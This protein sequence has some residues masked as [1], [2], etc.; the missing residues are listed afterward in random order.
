MLKLLA[1]STVLL[2]G[3]SSCCISR[4]SREGA[5]SEKPSMIFDTTE[6]VVN[7]GDPLNLECGLD[8]E[9]RHCIWMHEPD[10]Y[11][12]LDVYSNMYPGL[13]E[14]E[15]KENNQCGIIVDSVNIKHHG[16]WTC[17][18]FV[19][20]DSLSDSKKV[21]V[22]IQPTSPL[23]MIDTSRLEVV[24]TEERSVVCSVEIARP[25]VGMKWY[26]GDEDITKMS[27][28]V[29]TLTDDQ[30]SYK[31]VSTLSRRFLPKDDDK[32]LMCSIT[33]KTLP[34]GANASVPVA[35]MFKPIEKDVTTFYQIQLGSNYEVKF[36]FSSNPK[37][38]GVMWKFGDNLDV[39]EGPLVIPESQGRYRT[40]L[41]ELGSN[42][43]TAKLVI[44]EF[45]LEDSQKKYSLLV[46][47]D[48]GE[49]EYQIRLSVHEPPKDGV[50][51]TS[52]HAKIPPT[53]LSVSDIET[54]SN[55][56]SGGAIAGI[57]I[58]VAVVVVAI[59]AAGYAR[60]RQM[61]CFAPIGSPDPEAKDIREE[62]S[63][64]ES[65]RGHAATHPASLKDKL[66]QFTKV[67]KKPKTDQDVKMD[68]VEKRSLTTDEIKKE[69]SN[70][71]HNP[72]EKELSEVTQ[73]PEETGISHTYC[74]VKSH[75]GEN[76]GRPL[77]NEIMYCHTEGILPE[78]T[79]I[80]QIKIEPNGFEMKEVVYAELDL[81]K[82]EAEKKAD[83]KTDEKTEYAQI[84]GTITDNREDE[85]KE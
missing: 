62:H 36:N 80:P 42:M 51:E 11:Q 33:H 74:Q 20:G 61:F 54:E 14:P 85:K 35:V 38:H 46:G 8:G 43:Y 45:T 76:Q 65:A 22:T 49:T 31:S 48:I 26:L 47:N 73:L 68:D 41:E 64:T 32:T 60:Y 13:R 59:G 9:F 50:S 23:I 72:E 18:V 25:A 67:F 40:F 52:N 77:S 24:T 66:G 69:T 78:E 2:I 1:F 19:P 21:V 71:E 58:V 57:I 79:I 83:V 17:R 5:R 37:P 75:Y 70:K 30:G 29:E 53:E 15:N 6:V 63:D 4:S 16:V 7:P 82:G 39:A 44:E 84:V 55:N 28:N 34:S 56:L 27:E 12:V 3:K 10:I 81:S